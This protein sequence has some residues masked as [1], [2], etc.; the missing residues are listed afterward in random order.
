MERVKSFLS[1]KRFWHN[2][3]THFP[4]PM[5]I[6][7]IIGSSFYISL[8]LVLGSNL[9]YGMIIALTFSAA[10]S[11]ICRRF[12]VH[13]MLVGAS[14][15]IGIILGYFF[16]QGDITYW[17]QIVFVGICVIVSCW[18]RHF[19]IQILAVPFWFAVCFAATFVLAFF[20]LLLPTFGVVLFVFE[21][22]AFAPF[23][24]L[25]GLPFGDEDYN[26]L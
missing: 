19:Y 12:G 2:V 5:V 3:W 24:F 15:A 10:A 21:A 16:G 23:L 7:L 17:L 13:R 22:F 11:C 4:I 14:A 25:G 1:L 6:C 18:T 8:D 20:S 9:Y 26:S